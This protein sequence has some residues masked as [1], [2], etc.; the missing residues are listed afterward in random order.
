MHSAGV[1]HRDLKP[2]NIL[3]NTD[4]TLKVADFG[5]ARGRHNEEEELTDYVV[6]RYY[7]APELMLLPGGY[8][9]AVDL[10]SVGCIFAELLEMLEGGHAHDDRGPLFPGATAYPADTSATRRGHDMLHLIIDM[11]GTP[12]EEEIEELDCK[13]AGQ[14]VRSFPSRTGK[15]LSSRFPWATEVEVDLLEQML[16]FSPNRRITVDQALEHAFFHGVR[17]PEQEVTA[18]ARI[19]FDF[20]DHA[21]KLDE[22]SLRRHLHKHV[23][24]MHD[25]ARDEMHEASIAGA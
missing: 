14:Y 12:T 7:R 6:T 10:W 24:T 17:A 15:G 1:I 25:T 16:Q 23:A 19:K 3:V 11:L 9:E 22:G 13:G 21:D 20:E 8:F 5:L 4:C 18:P 2:A